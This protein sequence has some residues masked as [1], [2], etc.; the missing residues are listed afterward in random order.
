MQALAR[1]VSV[2]PLIAPWLITMAMALP[3]DLDHQSRRRAVKVEHIGAK[4]MLPA[5]IDPLFAAGA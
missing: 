3:I 4:R 5:K 2:P 1:Q